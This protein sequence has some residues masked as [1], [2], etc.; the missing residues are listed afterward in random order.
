VV[1]GRSEARRQRSGH[2]DLPAPVC[3]PEYLHAPEHPLA[4]WCGLEQ[5][6]LEALAYYEKYLVLTLDVAALGFNTSRLIPELLGGAASQPEIQSAM[7]RL[8]QLR[9]GRLLSQEE[10]VT[11]HA[12]RAQL[13]ESAPGK[14]EE[15]V[16]IRTGA[17]AVRVLLA[18]AGNPDRRRAVLD[19]LPVI[20]AGLRDFQILDERRV[21]WHDV[22][23]HYRRIVN[24]VGRLRKLEEFAAPVRILDVERQRL[25]EAVDGLIDNEHAPTP[26]LNDHG[27]RMQCLADLLEADT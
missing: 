2:I 5:R 4:Q 11:I 22:N 24:R 20:P 21:R 13:A 18:R 8:A 12:L 1:V 19:C 16:E 6:E 9:L 15:L 7:K 27:D 10:M 17:E 3:H 26:A 25:Q 14:W 23:H